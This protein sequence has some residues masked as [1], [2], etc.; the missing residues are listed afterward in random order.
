MKDGNGTAVGPHM[1][2]ILH[3]ISEP[4][5]RFMSSVEADV[6]RLSVGSISNT[7]GNIDTAIAVAHMGGE[8]AQALGNCVA[9]LGQA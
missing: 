3:L 8:T 6:A 9:P 2:V 7:S 4:E 5:Q 1:R